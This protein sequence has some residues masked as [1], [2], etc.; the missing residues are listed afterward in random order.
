MGEMEEL[1]GGSPVAVIV[2][3]TWSNSAMPRMSSNSLLNDD[4]RTWIRA[5]LLGSKLDDAMVKSRLVCR[6]PTQGLE[7][8]WRETLGRLPDFTQNSEYMRE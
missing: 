4:S 6:G 7:R 2:L 8:H 1:S 5:F 3:V